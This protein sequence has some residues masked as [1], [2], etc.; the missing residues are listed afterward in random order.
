MKVKKNTQ[1]LELMGHNRV[2]FK[3]Y[4]FDTLFQNA[5][6]I[7]IKSNGCFIT[8]CDSYYEMRHLLPNALLHSA[9]TQTID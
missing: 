8:N 6:D 3:N 5:T 9:I 2:P 1:D 7:I 4:K